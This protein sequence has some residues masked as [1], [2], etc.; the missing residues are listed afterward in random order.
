MACGGVLDRRPPSPL[1]FAPGVPTAALRA[2]DG[3]KRKRDITF[4]TTLCTFDAMDSATRQQRIVQRLRETERLEVADL[5]RAEQR[6]ELRTVLLSR[7]EE[8]YH[9]EVMEVYFTEF[10]TQ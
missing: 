4:G 8:A 10:V 7:L 2:P 5:A 6:E 9:G 1:A 3:S